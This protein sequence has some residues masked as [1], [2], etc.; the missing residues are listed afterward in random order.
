MTVN[1]PYDYDSN[2]CAHRLP[3][4]ICRIL[5]TQCPKYG[6]Q[7][8]TLTESSTSFGQVTYSTNTK[9]KLEGEKENGN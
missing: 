2:V 4:G 6:V 7:I 8:K 9:V 5:M 3:C 1:I